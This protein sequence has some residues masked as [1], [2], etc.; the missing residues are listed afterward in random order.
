MKKIAALALTAALAG[1]LAVPAL[2]AEAPSDI[3]SATGYPAQSGLL[4]VTTVAADPALADAWSTALFVLG[5]DRALELWRTGEGT[6]AG[7]ELIL[8]TED[9]RIYVTQGLEEGLQLHG[10]E[11]GYTY[12][13]VRR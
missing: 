13:I 2:A 1:S 6:V 9:Q 3:A 11:A 12:E 4:S 8:V 7:M 5:L 10:E